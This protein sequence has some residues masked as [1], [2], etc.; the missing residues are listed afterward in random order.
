[1]GQ[2][3]KEQLYVLGRAEKLL[4]DMR[5][6]K[7]N[8]GMLDGIMDEVTGQTEIADAAAATTAAAM[9]GIWELEDGWHVVDRVHKVFVGHT[10][11][12]Y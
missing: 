1:M 4:G 10:L 8:E 12:P 7:G 3:V 6:A 9:A 11:T 5:K 2:S